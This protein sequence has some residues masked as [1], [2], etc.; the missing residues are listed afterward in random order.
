MN[1]EEPALPQ[2]AP[3]VRRH[4]QGWLATGPGFRVWQEDEASARTWFALLMD[5]SQGA[6]GQTETPTPSP[7]HSALAR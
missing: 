2:T 3:S 1:N 4:Q 6:P 7:E 5:A